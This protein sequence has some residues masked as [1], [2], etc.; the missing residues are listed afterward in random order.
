MKTKHDLILLNDISLYGYHGILP[1]ERQRGQEFI[2]TVEM[3]VNFKGIGATD[4]IE[5]TVNY[6]DVIEKIKAVVEGQAYNLL[7]TVAEKISEEILSFPKVVGV[8]TTV[9]KPRPPLSVITS[10]VAV[11]VYRRR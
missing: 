1:E 10:G 2:V 4:N 9:G 11:T 7:E 6:A 5:D 8:K 3:E